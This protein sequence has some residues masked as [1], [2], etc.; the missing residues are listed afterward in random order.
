MQHTRF[1]FLLIVLMAGMHSCGNSETDKKETA[2]PKVPVPEKTFTYKD[3]L[4]EKRIDTTDFYIS[5]PH[6]FTVGRLWSSH[7]SYY[8]IGNPD[9]NIHTTFQ[10]MLIMFHNE[11]DIE[12]SKNDHPE[13]RRKGMILGEDKEWRIYGYEPDLSIETIIKWEHPSGAKTPIR[14]TG[15][16]KT[17]EDLEKM[18]YIF[19]TMKKK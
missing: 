2:T 4:V 1:K 19:S 3:S 8:P 5:I 6:E 14:V 11:G 12:L 9:T 15:Y 13:Q 7:A 16:G 17:T 18:L 10:G